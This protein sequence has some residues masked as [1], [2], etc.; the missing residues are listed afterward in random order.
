MRDDIGVIVEGLRLSPDVLEQLAAEIPGDQINLRRRRGFWTIAEHLSHLAFVQPMLFERLER[1]R[2]EQRPD[3]TPY[4]PDVQSD[5]GQQNDGPDEPIL[6]PETGLE[7]FRS[8]REQQVNLAVSLPDEFWNHEGTH[9][10]FHRYTPG[11]LLRHI[12]MHDHWHMYRM[13]EL[14]LTRD[15]YLTDLQ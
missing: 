6:S 13:E 2:D 8:W 4:L 14:W 12:L 10:E 11:I 7:R 9:P 3:F 1:F 15:Q 5:G